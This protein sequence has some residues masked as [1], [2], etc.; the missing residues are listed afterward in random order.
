MS[1]LTPN[2]FSYKMFTAPKTK[3]TES[4]L[5]EAIRIFEN[6]WTAKDLEKSIAKIGYSPKI[7]STL[8]AVPNPLVTTLTSTKYPNAKFVKL[9]GLDISNLYLTAPEYQRLRNVGLIVSTLTPIKMYKRWNSK[10]SIQM[11]LN[12]I[13]RMPKT[14]QTK[15]LIK[16]L[17]KLLGEYTNGNI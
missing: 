10:E 1:K 15:I 16:Y 5:V 3:I 17:N 2:E 11:Y 4:E 12:I 14:N 9:Y 13:K 7:R 6:F 8:S